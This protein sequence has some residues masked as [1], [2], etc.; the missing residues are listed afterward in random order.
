MGAS[1]GAAREATTGGATGAA[2]GASSGVGTGAGAATGLSAGGAA[3][4]GGAGRSGCASRHSDGGGSGRSSIFGTACATAA[5]ACTG[6][7]AGELIGGEGRGSGTGALGATAS[8]A[9]AGALANSAFRGA[10]GCGA[11][12]GAGTG[13]GAVL[14]WTS[15]ATRLS[16]E[17]LGAVG[18]AT[19]RPA[20]GTAGLLRGA[21]SRGPPPAVRGRGTVEGSVQSGVRKTSRTVS[22]DGRRVSCN[23]TN[24][25][26]ACNKSEQSSERLNSR[27]E[28][29][30]PPEA[31]P[32]DGKR[33]G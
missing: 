1:I 31:S 19:G 32:G 13:F 22:M 11:T 17:T 33:S 4:S 9:T 7:G 24:A 23:R 2:T 21:D 28:P 26:A 5:G 29:G 3:G 27:G 12:R 10:G 8:G 15:P 25:T 30:P 16:S 14:V 20:L 6:P 18:A